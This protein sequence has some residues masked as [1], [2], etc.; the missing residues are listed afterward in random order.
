MKPFFDNKVA[1]VTGASRGLGKAIA[2]DL[3]RAG[4][5]VVVTARATD[6]DPW[7]LPGTIDAT[8]RRI[9]DEGGVAEA[10]SADLSKDVQIDRLVADAHDAYGKVDILINNAAVAFPGPTLEMTS[11]QYDL[12]M[13]IQLRGAFVL[14]N[15]LVPQMVA[16][17]EG[18]VL[19]ISGPAAYGENRQP[20][21]VHWMAKAA[22]ERY[23]WGLAH[24]IDGKG[25]WVS[26]LSVD[27]GLATEGVLFNHTE[28]Q[29][30][31]MGREK[32]EVSGEA[33]VWMLR[34]DPVMFH[35]K[36]I[37]L[38]EMREQFGVPAYQEWVAG[39]DDPL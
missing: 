28:S 32:A 30:T 11:K 25:V 9:R 22:L 33:C 36:T 3:A 37:T 18:W 12:V 17:G 10:V 7:K 19:N 34:Q 27:F 23:T 8:V 6:K 13:G 15:K 2:L 20:M 5:K 4:A 31:S 35:G 1:L 24:E 26:C 39:R 38:T 14:C 29:W 21:L 16:R